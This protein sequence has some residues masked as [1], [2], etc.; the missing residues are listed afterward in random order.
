MKTL[1][2]LRPYNKDQ[3]LTFT[4]FLRP[5]DHIKIFC[6]HSLVD[7]TNLPEIYYQNLKKNLNI[8]NI[9]DF[10]KSEIQE[11]I[12]RCRLLRN[13]EKK[14]A[15]KHLISMALAIKEVLKIEKPNYLIMQTVDNYISDLMHRYCKKNTIK[16]IGM[17]G[18]PFN[19]YFRVTSQGE[20]NFNK[21]AKNS[22]DK[23]IFK[24]ML[25][26]RYVPNFNKKSVVNPKKSVFI[27][28]IRNSIKI[29]F[30]FLKKIFS[31]D[32]Y[33]YHYWQNLIVT[34]S[35]FNLFFPT[36]P[37]RN[38]WENNLNFKSRYN[39]YIPLQMYPEATIDYACQDIKYVDYYKN[40]FLFIKKNHNKFNIF[41]KEHPNIMAL[42]PASFY[43]S[44]K[45]DKRITVIPTYEN[46][47]YILEKID[48]TL[49]WTGTVGF[50]SLIRGVPVI[51]FCKP[52][53]ASGSR[54]MTI[55]QETQTSK[56]YKH[57]KKF[58][59]KKITLSEQ[60]KIFKYVSRQLYKGHFKYHGDWSSNNKNDLKDIKQMANSIKNL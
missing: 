51:S 55:K 37:G 9:I 31:F 20:A 49:V 28:W 13:I 60:K 30:F 10:N 52:Y 15:I 42:R 4:K 22:I 45:N 16:F 18:T 3:L 32:Y 58:Y 36:D 46:S 34:K 48:C 11:I 1:C 54:F 43:K 39:L 2:Y 23:K 59:K 17:V 50:D 26:R 5:Q 25:N 47:N 27:R 21:Q 41:I 6:E 56:I 12:T 8:N 19:N 53:Y 14:Q 24:N 33:N 7:Q 44:I 57:I 38:D 40:L 35:N 29:P